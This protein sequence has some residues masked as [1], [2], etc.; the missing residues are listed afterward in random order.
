[1]NSL[2]TSSLPR[3]LPD[4]HIPSSI[5]AHV[6]FS[7]WLA[8]NGGTFP[9]IS[10]A[11]STDTVGHGIIATQDLKSGDLIVCIPARVI[12]TVE[13]AKATT[14]GQAAWTHI[15]ATMGASPRPGLD[16]ELLIICVMMAQRHRPVDLHAAQTNAHWYPYL[17]MIPR[18]TLTPLMVPSSLRKQMLQG[19][20]LLYS[21]QQHEASLQKLYSMLFPALSQSHPLLFPLEHSSFDDFLWAYSSLHSRCFAKEIGNAECET[22]VE[23]GL[24]M[25]LPNQG[26]DDCLLPAIDMGNHCREQRMD[27]SRVVNQDDGSVFVV[28]TLVL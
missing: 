19:T 5:P 21:I 23:T 18:Q 16:K 25:M 11:P 17:N 12:L 24:P 14:A 20:S 3:A 27:I 8:L 6:L 13:N 4:L 10:F 22:S 1:M 2:Q 7:E 9:A 26:F 15:S 28:V